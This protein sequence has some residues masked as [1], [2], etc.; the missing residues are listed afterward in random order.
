MPAGDMDL[1]AESQRRRNTSSNCRYRD[2]T[3]SL[4]L[5]GRGRA[6]G[7]ATGRNSQALSHYQDEMI[8]ESCTYFA[9]PLCG[10]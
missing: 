5:A 4:S 6:C 3:E 8:P 9:A 2:S 10:L 7:A 1:A